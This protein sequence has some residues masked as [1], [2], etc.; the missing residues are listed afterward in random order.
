MKTNPAFLALAG[1]VMLFLT[2]S[3]GVR[4]QDTAEPPPPPPNAVWVQEGGVAGPGHVPE[5]RAGIGFL[6]FEAGLDEKTI[7]GAPFSAT[8]ST[9]STQ[10]L[11]DGNQIQHSSTGSIARDSQGRTR[12]EMTLPA[13]GAFAVINGQSLSHAVFLKDPVAGTRYVLEEDKKI[14]QQLP[15]P[16][17]RGEFRTKQFRDPEGETEKSQVVTT[18]LG[19]QT[20][21]GVSAEGTRTTRTI[22]AGEIG[23]TKPIVVVTERWYSADLQMVVMTKRSDP[24]SGDSTF[25]MTNVQR[26]EPS[27]SL[28][29]V[30]SD[31]TIAQAREHGVRTFRADGPL[32]PPE[33]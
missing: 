22:P 14:A 13:I 20:I 12:R 17:I 24:R 5:V 7:T 31:Y 32:P 26:G 15:E 30:P 28:F 2:M 1:S 33:Q 16:S 6:G 27:A 9:E 29:Q 21:G 11:A 4:A 25:Q 8:F 10:T 19:T 18:S 3:P 23:N